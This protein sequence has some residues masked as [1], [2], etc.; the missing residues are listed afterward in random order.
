MD[1]DL[2]PTVE[3]R[4]PG[5][6]VVRAEPLIV[7]ADAAALAQP[8]T[9]RGAHFVRN[10]F[11]MPSLA[12][13]RH[14][15]VVDGAVA[16]AGALPLAE[17]VRMGARTVAVT[18]QCA[19]DGRIGMAPLPGGEPWRRGALSTALWTGVPLRELLMRA[20]VRDDA[21]EV[22][23]EGADEGPLDG[24]G[25]GRFA[26]ALPLDEALEGGALLAWEMNGAPL[27]REHGAPLR[28]VVPGWYAMASV[29]WVA[30]VSV[31]AAPFGGFFQRDRYVILDGEARPVTR[32]APGA[33]VVRPGAGA[34]VAAGE[35]AIAGW[36]W[37]GHPI[38][39]VEISVDGEPWRPAA[40]EPPASPYAWCRFR[41]RRRLE[42]RGRHTVRARA[43]DVAGEVQP[44]A[45]RWNR[46]G[47]C[48]NA[49]EVA[50]FDVV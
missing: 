7:E 50:A 3:E 22:L 10:H 31:L 20:G 47:Y 36:A 39:Q 27:P 41:D 8:I 4:A 48:N 34:R 19:G 33:L 26:R 9:P 32:M 45:P 5:R 25:R 15:V 2:R 35:V 29:K 40:L 46:L 11:A 43:R 16:R 12:A 14:R 6:V 37:S 17:I 49:V 44:D 42:V 21:V 38:A 18:L 28:L 13:A 24:G 30:R 1:R 23:V